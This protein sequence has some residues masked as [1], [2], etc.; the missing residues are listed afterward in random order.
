MG[1][2]M[3]THLHAWDFPAHVYLKYIY[4]IFKA[5]G[6]VPFRSHQRDGSNRVYMCHHVET[7]KIFLGDPS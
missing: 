1:C 7:E 6:I 5:G 2:H 4:P 3:C